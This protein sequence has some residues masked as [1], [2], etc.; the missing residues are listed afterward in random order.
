MNPI[1]QDGALLIPGAKYSGDLIERRS[2]LNGIEASLFPAPAE[3]ESPRINTSLTMLHKKRGERDWYL[4]SIL[5]TWVT[6]SAEPSSSRVLGLR[7]L[8]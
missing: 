8:V 7:Q 6:L 5:E 1:L 4:W 2:R 3:G